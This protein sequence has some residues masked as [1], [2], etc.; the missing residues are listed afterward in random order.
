MRRNSSR[1]VITEGCKPKGAYI[2]TVNVVID[3]FG[4]SVPVVYSHIRNLTCYLRQPGI[5][6]ATLDSAYL[7][8]QEAHPYSHSISCR[9]TRISGDQ[10]AVM[11]GPTSELCGSVLAYQG[12]TVRH[13]SP[14]QRVS[15][16]PIALRMFT[17]G[18]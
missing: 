7:S 14:E 15:K 4:I 6:S 1:S 3:C 17:V 11:Y 18:L 8:I 10:C 5:P 9:V 13:H 2:C 12:P 16:P